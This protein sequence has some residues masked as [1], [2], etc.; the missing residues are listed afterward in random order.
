MPE[1]ARWHSVL[2]PVQLLSHDPQSG[3]P[4]STSV[5]AVLGELQPVGPSAT[6]SRSWLQEACLS[7]HRAAA[8]ERQG[9]FPG[10]VR[11]HRRDA[12]G[13]GVCALSE[14]AAGQHGPELQPYHLQHR[15][16]RARNASGLCMVDDGHGPCGRATLSSSIAC[17]AAKCGWKK[18]QAGTDTNGTASIT[19]KAPAI[20][21]PFAFLAG[22]RS[23]EI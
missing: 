7:L 14:R 11:L 5:L 16:R 4:C 15:Y 17:S 22:V 2:W 8:E 12:G 18:A 9:S 19:A 23:D 10:F 21:E 20:P 3:A 13:C 6:S 1:R